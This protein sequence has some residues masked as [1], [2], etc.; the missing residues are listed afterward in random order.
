MQGKLR[1]LRPIVSICIGGQVICS[2]IVEHSFLIFRHLSSIFVF[3]QTCSLTLS[4]RVGLC[5]W[6]TWL[7]FPLSKVCH[8]CNASG[9]RDLHQSGFQPQ[10]S[11]NEEWQLYV[12]LHLCI[13]PS[14]QIWQ[15][16]NWQARARVLD[17]LTASFFL[18][19]P[20]ARRQCWGKSP[21]PS[22]QERCSCWAC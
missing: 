14:I 18:P 5:R 12:L 16:R 17:S 10:R 21:T 2:R 20:I 15:T 3:W 22:L 6:R 19:Q 9:G 7:D 11:P 1:K 13:L 8:R 4:D